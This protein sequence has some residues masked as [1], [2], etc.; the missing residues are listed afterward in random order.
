MS[1][2]LI[3]TPK[4]YS[5]SLLLKF[6]GA[7][8]DTTFTDSSEYANTVTRNGSAVISTVQSKF[9]GS[10]GYFDGS[11]DHL[12]IATNSI[13]ALGTE[14]FTIEMW[15]YPSSYPGSDLYS[16]VDTRTSGGTSGLLLWIGAD[17]K[18]VCYTSASNNTIQR[19][20]SSIGNV[21][22]NAW[23]HL[24]ITRNNGL[25]YFYVNGI[26]Q[27][28]TGN[29]GSPDDL[30]P[31]STAPVRIATAADSP[32]NSRNY[33]GYI[34]DLRFV[35][36]VDLYRKNYW[37]PVP[38]APL[39]RNAQISEKLVSHLVLNSS[40]STG[41]IGGTIDVSSTHYAVSWWDGTTTLYSGNSSFGRDAFGGNQNITIY[42]CNI[43]GNMEG[44]FENIDISNNELN[45]VRAFYTTVD[46]TASSTIPGYGKWTYYYYS[47]Y[48][49]YRWTW[50][51]GQYIPGIKKYINVSSNNLDAGSIDQFYT[52]L[53]DGDGTLNVA[54]NPGGD[55][56]TTSIATNKGYT[57]YGST[58]PTV[59]LLL[60][61]NGTNGSTTFTDSG[62]NTRSITIQNGSPSLTITSPKYGTASLDT[63]NG[64]IGSTSGII[65]D[66]AS[67]DYTIEAW[68]YKT[69]TTAQHIANCSDNPGAGST[70]GISFWIDADNIVKLDNGETS[71]AA[72]ING[73]P[74]GVWTHVVGIKKNSKKYL[75]IDGI[76]S[77]SPV[78]QVGL[79]G[80]YQVYIG[81]YKSGAT[82][83][84]KG[85][86][87]IDD[88]R[89]IRGKAIYSNDFV[90]PTG[91][92]TSST[93]SVSPGITTLLL[94]GNGSNN[95][96]TFADSG[97]KNLTPTRNGNTVIST[98]QYKYGTASIYFDG[99]GDYLTYSTGKD[100]FNFFDS[101]FT[102]ECWIRPAVTSS[103]RCIFSKR[104][105]T[106]T[107]GGFLFDIYNNKLH[108]AGTNN[109][110]SWQL[111]ISSSASLYTG[112][113]THVAVTRLND[114]FKLF[115]NGVVDGS[116]SIENFIISGNTDNVV[117]GAGGATG[118][119][120]F[121]GY[122]DDLRI[123]R[124]VSLYNNNFTTP[125]VELTKYPT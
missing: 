124:G 8:N 99:T 108:C 79:S 35:K 3:S 112:V 123:I 32:G 7:N 31:T 52:D 60:N 90:P 22:L 41:Q 5:A 80:P 96:T 103:A 116:Q 43:S 98:A 122:I 95:S 76:L 42:P 30:S 20:I 111:E 89:L 101:N 9:G 53:L 67:H 29:S 18:W 94:N 4:I 39:S 47:Y 83:Y 61:F 125:S 48:N 13:F 87:K 14:D 62:S 74:T 63:N 71:G 59:E 16:L 119:Q 109:G 6:D 77:N 58:S 55:S 65:G 27:G 54:G 104:A 113:W 68:L 45:S 11:A 19:T 84:N 120:E 86:M 23:T 88:F 1:S 91:Q 2:L 36:G 110:S 46:S 50:V 66:I 51:P 93:T 114:T 15:A 57:V 37:Y 33:I 26:L 21:T 73:I 44:Y 40:K 81:G 115:I 10:S 75:Y 118:G 12:S 38:T 24:R 97:H 25:V 100:N 78:S 72:T 107:Y 106:S 56:D 64:V 49:R 82:F 70:R 85:T 117:I 69:T 105:N 121:N 17:Q 92:L 28:T 102:I 34:D